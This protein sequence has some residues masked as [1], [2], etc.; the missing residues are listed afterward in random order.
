MSVNKKNRSLWGS[1]SEAQRIYYQ[2]QTIKRLEK[3]NEKLKEKC[4]KQQY[5]I[6]ENCDLRLEIEQLKENNLAMQEEMCRT[7][8]KLNIIKKL[9]SW[10]EESKKIAVAQEHIRSIN[11]INL[12]LDKLNEL[13]GGK[14]D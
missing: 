3:E 12:V 8:E 11:A 2:R 9:R 7:W 13:E 6:K 5:A 4:E 1:R 14:N 10:L